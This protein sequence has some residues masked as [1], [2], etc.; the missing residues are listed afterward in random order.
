VVV[1]APDRREETMAA[2]GGKPGDLFIDELEETRSGWAS[3]GNRA[4]SGPKTREEGAAVRRRSLHGGLINNHAFIG[5]QYLNCD[6]KAVRRKQLQK[7]MDEGGQI[8][9]GGPV[10]S[11]PELAKWE[12]NAYGVTDEEIRQLEQEDLTPEALIGGGWRI[13]TTRNEPWPIAIGTSYVGEGGTYLRAKNE[14]EK[15]TAEIDELRQKFASWG[16]EDLDKATANAVVHSEADED[17]GSFVQNVIRDYC[18][19]PELQDKMREVFVLRYQARSG[20]F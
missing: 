4:R 8:Y 10:V 2:I 17:H 11:H 19:T 7:I 18:D 13:S 15:V 14:P 5:E 6:N 9:F 20:L 12:A 3:Q 16:V 1:T